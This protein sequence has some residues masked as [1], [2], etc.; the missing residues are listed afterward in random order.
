M[1]VNLILL[2]AGKGQRFL[3]SCPDKTD[4]SCIKQL[5]VI[6]KKP[7]INHVIDKLLPLLSQPQVKTLFVTLGANRNAIQSVLPPSISIIASELWAKGM[8]HTLAES[9]LSTEAQSSHIL[10]A[11]ADQQLI[12]SEHYQTLLEQCCNNPTKIIATL[13]DK[14]LM[15]PAIF[16]QKFF[17]QLT[18]LKGDKG[19]GKLLMQYAEHVHGVP[20][21]AAKSDID[22]FSDLAHIQKILQPSNLSSSHCQNLESV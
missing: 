16:P 12:T 14:Q 4:Q 2:A 15:A 8:G 21:S 13:C 11:L 1:Q 17:T 9:V 18:N 10:I 22:T 19:A 7:L 20:N 5:A 3:Q 6:N